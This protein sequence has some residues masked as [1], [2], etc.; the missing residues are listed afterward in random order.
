MGCSG[1]GR[2]TK[3]GLLLAKAASVRL[4]CPAQGALDFLDCRKAGLHL[5]TSPPPA[6]D[7]L[8]RRLR[9]T[10]RRVVR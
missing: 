4:R 3:S 1:A 5:L 8:A 7:A 10:Q 2:M 6:E 9:A